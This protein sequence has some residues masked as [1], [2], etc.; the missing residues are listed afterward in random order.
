MV[1]GIIGSEMNEMVMQSSNG[2][3]EKAMGR[4]RGRYQIASFCSDGRGMYS[5][6]AGVKARGKVS[7]LNDATDRAFDLGGLDH[8]RSDNGNENV[9]E[10]EYCL[11]FSC[12]YSVAP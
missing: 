5:S 11:L 1:H 3:C 9:D 7:C 12:Y 10:A 4:I 8:S 2:S 6:I